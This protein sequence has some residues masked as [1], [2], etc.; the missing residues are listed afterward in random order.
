MMACRTLMEK[1]T[2]VFIMN[3]M[4]NYIKAIHKLGEIDK[5]FK[6]P[7]EIYDSEYG[8]V[9]D[10][11][12]KNLD[13]DVLVLMSELIL[14]EVYFLL[15]VATCSGNVIQNKKLINNGLLALFYGLLFIWVPFAINFCT[16]NNIKRLLFKRKTSNYNS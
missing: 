9:G 14:F 5:L 6:V 7:Q 2:V 8:E 15:L 10:T 1:E 11:S 3:Q 13:V 16:A 12:L 4:K